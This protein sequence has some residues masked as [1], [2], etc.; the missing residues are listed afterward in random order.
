MDKI[1]AS[2]YRN[3]NSICMLN[4][5]II[6]RPLEFFVLFIEQSSIL[7]QNKSLVKKFTLKS[8]IHRQRHL[9]SSEI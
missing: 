1:V 9:I 8:K 4:N 7:M 5:N 2:Y 3:E 6:L